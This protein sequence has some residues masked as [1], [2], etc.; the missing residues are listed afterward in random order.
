MITLHAPGTTLQQEPKGPDDHGCGGG[1]VEV[2]GGVDVTG[3]ADVDVTGGMIDHLACA[4]NNSPTRTQ[5]TGPRPRV[6][7]N[8][9]I[10]R[11]TF[12]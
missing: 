8:V 12:V 4:G 9:K 11:S 6:K 1:D 3:G 5:G 7:A 2:T 10:R